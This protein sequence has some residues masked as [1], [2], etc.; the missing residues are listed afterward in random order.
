MAKKKNEGIDKDMA[1]AMGKAAKSSKA[2]SDALDRG[3]IKMKDLV[4]TANSY[5]STMQKT[6]VTYGKIMA[7]V[8]AMNKA[9]G[10]SKIEADKVQGFMM[11]GANAIDKIGQKA[12]KMAKTESQRAFVN[13]RLE[14]MQYNQ[15]DILEQMTQAQGGLLK[16]EV[17][18]QTGLRGSFLSQAAEL[19]LMM[20]KGALSESEYNKLV[21]NLK[22]QQD[23]TEALE[24]Q[25]EM[26]EAI[27][28]EILDIKKN[29]ESWGKSLKKTAATAKSIA[30]DPKA[31]GLFA[32]NEAS[33]AA[34]KLYE[35]FED[36]RHEGM[37]AGQA[38]DASFKTFSVNSMLGLSDTKGA[39]KGLVDEFGTINNVSSDTI[40]Q[41][42][43]VAHE[44]GISGQEAASLTAQMSQMA[45]ETTEVAANTLEYTNELAKANGIAPGKIT[46]EMAANTKNMH[47]FTKGGSK[48][49][50]KIAVE[51]H[52]IGISM[53]TA[54]NAA[55]GLL[56]Y[57]SSI[58]AQMEASVLLG[59][60]INLDKARQLALQGKSV[61]AA[62]EV[63]NQMGGIAAFNDMNVVQQ[64]AAAKA[65]NMSVADIKKAMDAEQNK[66]KLSEENADQASEHAGHMME[67]AMKM[68]GFLKN[69]AMLLMT[70]LQFI[71][72]A[73]GEK[74]MGYAKAMAHWAKEKA[75]KLWNWTSEK[76]HAIWKWANDK[77]NWLFKAG[78]WAKEKAH[79]LWKMAKESSIG[80]AASSMAEKLGKSKVGGMVKDKAKSLAGGAAKKGGDALKSG[81]DS[82][83]KTQKSASKM[84]AGGGAGKSLKKLAGG[85]EAFGKGKVI[86]GALVGLPAT[87]IGMVTMVAAIPALAFLALAGIPAATGL[88]ALAKGVAAMGKG[89][90]MMGALVVG[91]LSLSMLALGGAAILFAQG[92]AVG[93][94]LMVVSMYALVGALALMGG[95]GL[96]GVG[97]IGVALVLAMGAALMLMGLGVKFAAEG[98]AVLVEAFIGLFGA[99]TLESLIPIF[100]LGPAL[101]MAAIG[102]I[103]FSASLL[104]L[105]FAALF[106]APA[107]VVLGGA[108]FL[109][110]MGVALAAAGLIGISTVLPTLSDGFTQIAATVPGLFALSGILIMFAGAL[111]TL[112]FASFFGAPALIVLAGAMLVLGTGVALAAV[113]M[114]IMAEALPAMAD[115]MGAIGKVAPMLGLASLFLMELG[116]AAFF[117]SPGLI[118]GS[119]ALGMLAATMTMFAAAVTL[120]MPGVGML[121]QLGS[122]AESFAMIAASMWSM[123]AGIAAFATAGLLTLPTIM[124]LIA[125]SFVAPILTLLGDSI[126]YDLQGGGGSSIQSKPEESEMKI[127]I[128]EVR[129][130]RAAFQSPGVIN[131]DGQ[132]V[133]DVI[134]LAVSNSGIL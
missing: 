124:G 79:L 11:A 22:V 113:G 12:L 68:G 106:G 42:G 20:S 31:L 112:A 115:G 14:N 132:K 25:M 69:N 30:S 21:K 29:T 87:A 34:G 128:E 56:D 54:A 82:V 26:E 125:L 75:Y 8:Y 16:L 84:G 76:A 90:V 73:N 46:K 78:M 33:K 18:R 15:K 121:I 107:L 105:A 72:S 97:F 102:I 3:H 64:E 35:G 95:L 27:A 50:A 51:A 13:Q 94:M 109:L 77:K 103:A 24:E 104:V 10:K 99:I 80:K 62:K 93:T 110:G 117:S 126:N 52:K 65:A 85:V 86:L 9:L 133:G 70:A 36:L 131:M 44:M 71:M 127:L 129:Q 6:D 101:V 4:D 39:V 40:D 19:Q 67:V 98:M 53:D 123:A 81:G 57:E 74:A 63:V 89:K 119:L 2:I 92:G 88:K 96:S 58:E 1:A 7:N 41:I 66:G 49:F 45:G 134:G 114:K 120:A 130:L 38:L 55:S 17:K 32:L 83:E 111:M 47:K 100:M 23:Q 118:I 43:T 122:M 116:A 59:K 61:Q 28:Q 91:A 5:Q 37:S 108:M 60:E 48:E